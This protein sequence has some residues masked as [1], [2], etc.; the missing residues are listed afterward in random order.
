[1]LIVDKNDF[2]PMNRNEIHFA[3]QKFCHEQIILFMNFIYNHIIMCFQ[4]MLY[5]N[6]LA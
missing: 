5:K 3:H 2:L 1:M 4:R 6:L